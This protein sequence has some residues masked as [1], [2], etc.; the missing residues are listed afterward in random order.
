MVNIFYFQNLNV[1]GGTE[2]FL[3]YLSKEYNNF[4]VMYERADIEQVKRL[5]ERVECKW[6][7]GADDI[8]CDRLFVNY[9]GNRIIDK[10]TAN[11][12][13]QII[14]CDYKAQGI[15]PNIHPRI[16]KFI[17]VSK[18]VCKSFE[19]ITGKKCELIYNSIKI[20]KPKKLL[21]LISATRLTAEKGKS[22]M[23]KLGKYLNKKGISYIWYVFT[24]DI[25]AIDNPNIVYM[26][27]RLD[28]TTYINECDYLV[29][30]SDSEAYCYSVVEALSLKVPVIITDLPVYKE[31][32][33]DENNAIICDM[34]MQNIPIDRIIKNDIKVSYKPPKSE[35]N[36]YL[37]NNGKYNPKEK[38]YVKAIKDYYDMEYKEDKNM[39]SEPYLVEHKR[40]I[41]LSE[42]GLVKIVGK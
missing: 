9:Y 22:R 20:D 17:G 12:I 15:L 10:T 5:S 24:D 7:N 30:L 27:P 31:I 11:E 29:Q 36:R 35:W 14:H 21:K 42:L 16:T 41:Y 26:K 37:D 23:E 38:V 40:A 8:E 4:I 3:Y 28:I 39:F 6:W 1:V 13:I 34:D 32:G 2:S 25:R 19:E 18:Q 33:I